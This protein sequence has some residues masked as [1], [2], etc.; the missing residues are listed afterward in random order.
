MKELYLNKPESDIASSLNLIVAEFPRVTFGSYPKL[1]NRY[2]VLLL[3]MYV[4]VLFNIQ[5]NYF[6][7]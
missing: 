3:S 6:F 4:T 7:N 5:G 2:V 1:Y